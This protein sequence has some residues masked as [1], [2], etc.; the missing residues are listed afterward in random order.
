MLKQLKF[1]TEC[2][3]IRYV[4]KRHLNG[5]MPFTVKFQ[6]F[7]KKLE[8]ELEEEKQAFEEAQEEER[9]RTEELRCKAATE[10]Q[11]ALRGT[12]A[13]RWSTRELKRKKE[14]EKRLEE[15]KR[16]WE[17]IKKER[18]EE[19][20]RIEEV[21][22]FHR[23][24]M[25]RRR[26]EYEASKEQ[27]R[28]RLE[29]E[30]RLEQQR[31]KEEDKGRRGMEIKTEQNN[32]TGVEE[33]CVKEESQCMKGKRIYEQQQKKDDDDDD[34]RRKEVKRKEEQN[35][36]I[37]MGESTVK[38]ESQCLE[39]DEKVNLQVKK[40]EEDERRE[41][42]RKDKQSN[43]TSVEERSAKDESKRHEE[44]IERRGRE[45]EKRELVR[46]SRGNRKCKGKEENEERGEIK[47]SEDEVR[48]RKDKMERIKDVYKEK[49]VLEADRNMM[50]KSIKQDRF[51]NQKLSRKSYQEKN[52]DVSGE[53][54][55][56]KELL[57]RKHTT[58]HPPSGINAHQELSNDR[59][60]SP[61]FGSL[62]TTGHLNSGRSHGTETDLNGVEVN[63][64]TRGH[65]NATTVALENC[66]PEIQKSSSVCL[67][68]SA[69][70]KRLAWIKNCTP[71]CILSLQNKKKRSSA[72]QQSCKRRARR[73]K[74][75]SLPPLSVDTIL[76]TGAWSSL[77]QVVDV[78]SF[79]Y[80]GIG[81][82][83][84]ILWLT[85]Q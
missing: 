50:D 5:L 60:I 80:M 61:L 46:S 51:D 84:G 4:L 18:E 38:E 32:I 66:T 73:G 63:M 2:F 7:I 10:I 79:K 22:R 71:W 34:D 20:K 48:E 85:W 82:F 29:E 55:C 17:K 14:E 24:E 75:P 45:K 12:L 56:Q 44:N 21:K 15:E 78:I 74:L 68:D 25:E 57:N 47:G 33:R 36:I 35:K 42:K 76:K 49:T 59:C 3:V 11:A 9:K 13:R 31:R 1:N 67:P 62:K 27:E 40:D 23:E 26:A 83:L 39:K 54:D 28:H 69:E 8:K 30:K 58:A 6:E 70:Q 41:V 37:N 72:Q 43:I 53:L 77:E 16:E 52:K 65:Q 19:K 64:D 81:H